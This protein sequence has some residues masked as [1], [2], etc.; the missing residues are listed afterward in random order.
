M[1]SNMKRAGSFFILSTYVTS[2]AIAVTVFA[3]TILKDAY[4]SN[5]ELKIIKTTTDNIQ[6]QMGELFKYQYDSSLTIEENKLLIAKCKEDVSYCKK[7]KLI[8]ISK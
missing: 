7:L 1:P 8:H 3:G 6:V 2:L 4:D 5:K